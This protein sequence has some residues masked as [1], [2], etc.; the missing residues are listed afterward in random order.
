MNTIT[1]EPQWPTLLMAAILLGDIAMSIKPLRF[2]RQCLSG[3]NFPENWW[4]ALILIKSVAVL[5][6]LIGLHIPG[7]GIAAMCGI[8]AYF[9]AATI[10]HIRAGYLKQSFW[11]NCL[12]MLSLSIAVLLLTILT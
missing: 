5:G 12:G 7:F 3:V 8:I 6:L 9:C 10:A 2:I 4:W 1:S 11:I